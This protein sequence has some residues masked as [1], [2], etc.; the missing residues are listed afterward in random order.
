MNL[1]AWFSAL[2]ARRNGLGFERFQQFLARLNYPQNN[3]KIIHV[4]GT[5]GKGS[6]SYLLAKVLEE[7]GFKTGLF[8][9][10]HVLCPTERIQLNGKPISEKTLMRLCAEIDALA[11]AQLNFFEML[12]ATALVYFARRK[13]EYVVLETGLGGRKDPTNVCRPALGVISSVGMD[14]TALLGNT[15]A[16][17]AHEK[18]GIIKKNTPVLCGRLPR[19]AQRVIARAAREKN[20]PLEVINTPFEIVKTDWKKQNMYLQIPA[21]KRPWPLHLLG[22]AQALNAALVYRAA[23]VLGVK[24]T[25]VKKAF[26][27]VN[28]PVRFEIIRTRKNT[29]ILDGAHNPQAVENL[30]CWWK[31]SPFYPQAVLLCGF[32]KDKDYPRMMRLLAPHFARIICTAPESPRAVPAEQLQRLAGKKATVCAD[33]HAAVGA[34][35]AA[36]RWV[37]CAGSFYL[38]GAVR[39]EIANVRARPR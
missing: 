17:I 20:A 31:K 37:L 38:A 3:C 22:D 19:E 35:C 1:N 14:H 26:A 15:L 7:N 8:I 32:M 12:T 28:V 27:S 6:V 29:F 36:G 34:A 2:C 25:A 13:A 33:V 23:Q 39:R 24:K 30:V 9:S 5:N 16:Q 11:P 4:A 10:P 18:A 21:H